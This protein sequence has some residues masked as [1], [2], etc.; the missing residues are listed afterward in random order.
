MR[1]IE[2]EDNNYRQQAKREIVIQSTLDHPNLLKL[3]GY[4]WD[5]HH[6]YLILEYAPR[7]QLY[8]HIKR[9]PVSEPSI[10]KILEQVCQGLAY[11]HSHSI[12]HR[13]I[14]P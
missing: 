13:D 8:H 10:A 12:I 14:K 11:L 3:Y 9:G 1:R 4:F 6:I 2:L 7:G 5:T